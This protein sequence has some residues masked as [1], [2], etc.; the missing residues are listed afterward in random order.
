MS[1]THFCVAKALEG[2]GLLGSDG[3]SFHDRSDSI[4]CKTA[5]NCS[6]WGN[7]QANTGQ[8]DG[9][10]RPR[11]GRKTRRWWCLRG[12]KSPTCVMSSSSAG[13]VQVNITVCSLIA[14][15]HTSKVHSAALP[16]ISE[17]HS[18]L[19]GWV[20]LCVLHNCRCVRL[21]TIYVWQNSKSKKKGLI[22][23]AMISS[24][25]DF[26]GQSLRESIVEFSFYFGFFLASF[27]LPLQ[28]QS[29]ISSH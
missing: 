8:M 7:I 25:K 4:Q 16:H 14:V 26:I 24:Y 9:A 21:S 12:A 29:F 23:C 22:P 15:P 11:N 3:S 13:H 5:H 2:Q 19:V 17:S 28:T 20:E 6:N 27:C 18:V 1:S 10:T